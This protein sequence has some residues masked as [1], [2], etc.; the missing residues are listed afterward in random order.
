MKFRILLTAL[1]LAPVL[2]FADGKNDSP[3][4]VLK[5]VMKAAFKDYDYAIAMELSHGEQKEFLR[6]AARNMAYLQKS[7][8]AGDAEAKAKLA[9][10]QAKCA[11]FTCEIK[12]EKIDGD[13]AVVT[14]VWKIGDKTRLKFAFFMK[15]S[16][17]WKNISQSD[18]A[19][20]LKTCNGGK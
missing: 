3:S 15:V 4:E 13:L 10:I 17:E 12:D 9:K 7:A 18:Y 11:D 14:V 5:K 6:M 2:A 16:G 8:A 1:L 19:E 20:A